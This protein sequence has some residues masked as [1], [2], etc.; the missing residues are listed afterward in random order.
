MALSVPVTVVAPGD[1][2]VIDSPGGERLDRVL[3]RHHDQHGSTFR[4]VTPGGVP[5]VHHYPPGTHLLVVPE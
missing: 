5:V 4:A 3:G 1:R 2:L